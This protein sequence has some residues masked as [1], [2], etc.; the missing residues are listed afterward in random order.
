MT[1][2]NNQFDHSSSNLSGGLVSAWLSSQTQSETNAIANA[3]DSPSASSLSKDE[4]G[5]EGASLNA[6]QMS[7]VLHFDEDQ[8]DYGD[9]G[10]DVATGVTPVAI[11]DPHQARTKRPFH[12]QGGAKLTLIASGTLLTVMALSSLFGGIFNTGASPVAET[13]NVDNAED[14][15]AT[16]ETGQPNGE[17]LTALALSE[18]DLQLQALQGKK[19]PKEKPKPQNVAVQKPPKPTAV[20][21]RIPRSR[22]PRVQP[23]VRPVASRPVS[24]PS[25]PAFLPATAP[26]RVQTPQ[27]LDPGRAWLAAAQAGSFG[28][29]APSSQGPSPVPNR[30][31]GA[32]QGSSGNNFPVVPVANRL[33]LSNNSSFSIP[34]VSDSSTINANDEALI[35]AGGQGQP[36]KSLMVGTTAKATL[37]T[38]MAWEASSRGSDAQP[39]RYLIRLEEDL[40]AS[41][42]SIAL[43]QGTQLVAQHRANASGLVDLTLVAA[44]IDVNGQSREISLPSGALQV[45]GKAGK[46]LFAKSRGGRKSGGGLLATLGRVA[47]GSVRQAAELYTRPNTT[48]ASS[49]NSTFVSSSNQSRNVLAGTLQGGSDALVRDLESRGQQALS[50]PRGASVP[51][52]Y[53]N[54]GTPLEIYVNQSVELPGILVQ[55]QIA[56]Q[57]QLQAEG[58]PPTV[59]QPETVAAAPSQQLEALNPT[60]LQSI[61]SQRLRFA[62]EVQ[63]NSLSLSPGNTGNL[64]TSFEY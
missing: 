9:T 55:T 34:S 56:A 63:D 30:S 33:P 4:I 5:E 60:Q 40:E 45:N 32:S 12:R 43:P 49:G 14:S 31:F 51:I 11:D 3:N 61:S 28:Q 8:G 6:S 1:S 17:V 27:N 24:P 25:R 50:Q 42:G 18:Q 23:S 7:T 54:A 10:A 64:T 35:L 52:W 22:Q 47:L 26:A 53:A 21:A 44:V 39:G 19:A 46:P 38:P 36:P 59:I 29:G 48:I 20:P 57:P 62:K 41:D 58:T 16:A 2:Q 13:A 37:A 15:T